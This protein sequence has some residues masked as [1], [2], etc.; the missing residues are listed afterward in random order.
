MEDIPLVPLNTY[1]NNLMNHLQEWA[2]IALK[3]WP[4]RYT[5]ATWWK[6]F[7]KLYK[8]TMI[9]VVEHYDNNGSILDRP[10]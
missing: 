9:R 5:T 4:A 10:L 2:L 3:R 7:N 8:D 1:L 6:D